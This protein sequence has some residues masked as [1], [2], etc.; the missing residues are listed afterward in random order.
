MKAFIGSMTGRVFATLL[1]GILVSAALTQW[2][3]PFTFRHAGARR[4]LEGN[5]P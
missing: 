5:R 2:I 3:V 1:L 4:P